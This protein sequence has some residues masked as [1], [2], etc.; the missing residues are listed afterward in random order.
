LFDIES[1]LFNIGIPS[2]NIRLPSPDIK[3]L[4]SNIH[5]GA[6][7]IDL[8]LV[9]MQGTVSGLWLGKGNMKLRD[10]SIKPTLVPGCL[11]MILIFIEDKALY[12]S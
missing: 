6:S 9:N 11:K 5:S 10:C 8:P 3:L 2:F 12:R 7:N 1:R 4:P